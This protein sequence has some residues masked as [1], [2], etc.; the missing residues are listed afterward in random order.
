M[1]KREKLFRFDRMKKMI[2]EIEEKILQKTTIVENEEDHRQK[3]G[4]HVMYFPSKLRAF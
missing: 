3:E 1:K 4:N 2:I